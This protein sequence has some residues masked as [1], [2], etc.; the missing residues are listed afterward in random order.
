MASKLR[1]LARNVLYNLKR[2][3]PT[4]VD[5][6]HQTEG[7]IDWSTGAADPTIIKYPVLRA[8]S[9]PEEET[10]RNL[11]AEQI[12]RLIKNSGSIVERGERKVLVDRSDFPSNVELGI[13]GWYAIIAGTRYQIRR[14]SDYGEGA[15]WFVTLTEDGGRRDAQIDIHAH[16]LPTTTQEADGEL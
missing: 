2:S 10:N 12:A 8:V 16:D 1:S 15:G 6:Y 14:I 11:L 7:T 5:F 4:A 3:Y 13:Q 9:M